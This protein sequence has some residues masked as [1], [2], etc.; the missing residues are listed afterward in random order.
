MKKCLGFLFLLLSLVFVSC[1]NSVDTA[2]ANDSVSL[3]HATVSYGPITSSSTSSYFYGGVVFGLDNNEN[4]EWT[5]YNQSLFVSLDGANWSTTNTSSFSVPR[6]TT[7]FFLKG[8]AYCINTKG[9][10][11]IAI[12]IYKNKDRI[13]KTSYLE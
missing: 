12:S 7:T 11:C 8:I 9:Q 13:S 6:D 3:C 4:N 5:I 10:R 2:G 1:S